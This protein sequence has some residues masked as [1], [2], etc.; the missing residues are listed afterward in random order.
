MTGR[1]GQSETLGFALILGFTLISVGA[2][3][4]F[5]GT[6]LQTT[7]ERI[8]AQNAENAMSQFDSR[9][10]MVALGQSDSQRIDFGAG[11]EGTYAVEPD[12]GWIRVVHENETNNVKTELYNDSLG[13]VTYR[14]GTREIGY[15]GGGVWRKDATSVMLSPPE[16]HFRGTTLTLPI[17]Q[18]NGEGSVSGS[19]RANISRDDSG[20]KIF[21]NASAEEPATNPVESGIVTVTVKS[22][23]YDAWAQY[24]RTRTDG[25]VTEY[26]TNQT[27]SIELLAPATQGNFDM[28]LDGNTMTL[29]GIQTHQIDEFELTLID[30]QDDQANF[31]NLDWSICAESGGQE[32]ET[33]VIPGNGT[34]DGDTA[35]ATF[36]YSP[37]GSAY[38][39]WTT[40]AFTFEA[41]TAGNDWNGDGDYDDK[42]L[43]LNLTSV[44]DAEYYEENNVNSMS[45]CGFDANSFQGS[46]T[47]AGHDTTDEPNTYSPPDT[48]NITFVVNHY[49]ALLGPTVDIEVADSNQ[50]SVS[51]DISTGYLEYNS[52]EN[53]YLTYMHISENPV[54]VTMG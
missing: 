45:N 18:L 53:Y 11:Q 36:Y 22:E 52:S 42:R 27:A 7:Q 35:E 8:G 29:Q 24:F 12:A 28:P 21:P 16:F 26:E 14:D 10:S 32:F 25:D 33:R 1:R 51:E 46:T 3:A 54:N 41:E 34:S 40:T 47:F 23:Y 49:L 20:D 43:V 17:V 5:G 50:N 37:N 30:D 19:P 31:D 39:T 13:A 6:T 9:A 38:Q 44:E 15:Q 4:A 2:I 48:E